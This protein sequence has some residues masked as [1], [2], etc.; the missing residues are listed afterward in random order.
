MTPVPF[1]IPPGNRAC[2]TVYNSPSDGGRSW[3]TDAPRRAVPARRPDP[4]TGEPPL[5][6]CSVDGCE[7]PVQAREFC[8][9][10]YRRLMRHGDPL[11]RK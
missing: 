7:Q 6:L 5:R 4:Q 8:A 9:K 3:Q 1:E 2:T 10:H 11:A